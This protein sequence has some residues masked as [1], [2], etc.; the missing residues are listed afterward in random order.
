MNLS[1]N[2]AV[3]ELIIMIDKTNK[4]KVLKQPKVGKN[5]LYKKT[6]KKFNGTAKIQE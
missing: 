2:K 1:T 5:R 3:S 6:T 4:K